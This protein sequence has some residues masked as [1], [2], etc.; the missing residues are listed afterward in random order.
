MTSS[1]KHNLSLLSGVGGC[2]GM[3]GVRPVN[4][5]NCRALFLSNKV[6]VLVITQATKSSAYQFFVVHKY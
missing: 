3:S 6:G 1:R 4:G 2:A 5:E